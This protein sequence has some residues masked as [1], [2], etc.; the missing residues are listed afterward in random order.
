MNETAS[1][2]IVKKEWG[3]FKSP[4]IV[5]I[6]RYKKAPE[7]KDKISVEYLSPM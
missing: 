2:I 5:L 4:R 7:A 1:I 6:E 3:F